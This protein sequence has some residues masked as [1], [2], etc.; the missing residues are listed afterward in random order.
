MLISGYQFNGVCAIEPLRHPDG[1]VRIFL[2]QSNYLNARGIALN[3]YGAGPF[4][5]FKIPNS[6][7]TAGVYAISDGTGAIKY[8]GECQNLSARYNMGYGN[9][10]PRNCFKGGQETNC[11]LN[12]LIYEATSKNL[13]LKLWFFATYDYKAVEAEL[14]A[15]IR[16]P[17]NR[18]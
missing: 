10:S 9:I 5:K 15:K 18:V 14:R 1:T 13:S 6:F 16:A 11:R 17:W 7:P 8:I 12:N 3:N 4:C 2:P